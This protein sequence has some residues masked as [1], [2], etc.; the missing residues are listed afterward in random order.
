MVL[1]KHGLVWPEWHP[2]AESHT[3]KSLDINLAET[4]KSLDNHVAESLKFQ[5]SPDTLDDRLP[6][7]KNERKTNGGKRTGP[8]KNERKKRTGPDNAKYEW[9]LHASRLVNAFATIAETSR[10]MP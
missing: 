8:D 2:S 5:L 7:D 3:V 6:P 9:A 10:K 1:A 4:E